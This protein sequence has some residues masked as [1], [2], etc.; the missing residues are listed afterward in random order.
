MADTPDNDGKAAEPGAGLGIKVQV[1]AEGASRDSKAASL[2]FLT[3]LEA[4]AILRKANERAGRRFRDKTLAR[5][6]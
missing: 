3:K 2:P 1:F 4:L 5:T 6:G